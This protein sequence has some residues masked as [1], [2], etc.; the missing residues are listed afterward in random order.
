MPRHKHIHFAKGWTWCSGSGQKPHHSDIISEESYRR[1]CHRL[2]VN[3]Y[4]G[5]ADCILDYREPRW[6]APPEPYD[7]IPQYE[8]GSP[9][10]VSVLESE[11]GEICLPADDV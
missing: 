5:L 8:C 1:A 9:A 4:L 10:N 3:S 6:A 2:H 11:L 7:H